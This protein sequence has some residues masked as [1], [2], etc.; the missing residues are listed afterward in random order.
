MKKLLLITVFLSPFLISQEFDKKFLETLP[1]DVRNSVEQKVTAQADAEKPVYRRASSMLDKPINKSNV[2]GSNFFDTMQ[3]SFMP[4]NEPNF[5]SSYVLDFGD[6]L[7]IQLIGQRE[8]KEEFSIKRDGSINVANIGSISLS[9]LSIDQASSL[10]KSKVESIYIGTDAYI[11]LVNVRDIQVLITGNAYNPGIYTLNGNSNVLHALSM[12]GGIDELGS[13][14]EIKLIR[15]NKHIETIDL[16]NTFVYGKSNHRFRLRS[17]DSIVVSPS[18]NIINVLSGVNRIG[19]YE[20]KQN[21]TLYDLVNYAN[22]LNSSAD[23]NFIQLQSLN[24]DSV[25]TTKLSVEDF[26]NV[27]AEDNDTLIIREYV[28]YNISI[29][30][31]ITSPGDYKIRRGD[32]L[33][34]VIKRAGGYLQSSY[35]FGGYLDN[36]K[37]KE[38]N[39]MASKSLEKSFLL[40]MLTNGSSNGKQEGGEVSSLM[41]IFSNDSDYVAPGRKIV[42]FDLDV[43]KAYP[44]LDT[45]LEDGDALTIPTNTNQVY[46]FGEVSNEGGVRYSPNKSIEYYINLSGGI[47]DSAD[48]SSAYILSPNGE[49]INYIT[50]NGRLSFLRRKQDILIYPGS[51][52]F[53][54]REGQIQNKTLIASIW[55]PI[56]SSF[57]LSIA[58]ISALN[59]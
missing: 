38:L 46:L 54:P 36:I 6:I 48:I 45:V 26:P 52:V 20:L 31:A 35:P 50:K 1:D 16:Y 14:R 5:D 59:N 22:G 55:A 17:G 37:S 28:Y 8:L 3:S 15:N 2:F 4:T 29:S 9:G 25:I 49:T 18:I 11:S 33:S 53:I 19:S 47:L 56:I 24:K 27:I 42:E 30:G 39:L 23:I 7:E 32:T 10:I 44:E 57:A 58:S 40:S 51:I 34:T 21:E 41:S 43:I 12:A 13:F